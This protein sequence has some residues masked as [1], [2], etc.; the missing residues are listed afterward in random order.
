MTD[1]FCITCTRRS[2]PPQA[3]G[4]SRAHYGRSRGARTSRL[5][6]Q[7]AGGAG[8]GGDGT[9]TAVSCSNVGFKLLKKAGWSEGKGLGIHGQ[10][11]AR[12]PDKAPSFE[13]LQGIAPQ[14]LNYNS[15][16]LFE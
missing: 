1:L 14:L 3:V 4:D 7:H 8:D 13:S 16:T 12:A 2:R 10:V 15:T 5:E 9:T 6:Q 11:R